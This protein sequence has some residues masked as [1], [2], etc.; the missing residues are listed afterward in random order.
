[1]SPTRESVSQPEPRMNM[2]SKLPK[3]RLVLAWDM[4]Y[5][6]NYRCPYCFYTSAGWT[7]LAKKN[8]Y[9]SPEEWGRVWERMHARY[10]NCQLRITA[11]EPFTYPRFVEVIATITQWHDVQVTTNGSRTDELHEFVAV[12]DPAHAEL[13]CTF[14]PLNTDFDLF[15]NNVL[16]LRKHGF[17]A[18]VCYLAYPAQLAGMP[19]FKRRFAQNGVHMNL[20]MYWGTYQAKDY[21]FAYSP[22][23]RQLIKEVIGQEVGPETVN[24][25]PIPVLGKICGAGQRYAVV[26]ADGKIYRCGQLCHEDQSIA[27]IFAP[28]V[29]LLET[30]R[31]CPVDYCRCKEFQSAWGDDEKELMLQ[32]N[33]LQPADAQERT[34]GTRP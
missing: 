11:G 29:N 20:A 26:Q 6:C 19:D 25:D 7:E 27:S 34:L 13:D 1:M 9:K 30:G 33:R 8:T 10:G 24:L 28:E 3:R 22:A 17:T 31:P 4:H 16:L 18:N 14:H 32:E 12:V 5:N 2:D 15:L 23:E 21:P